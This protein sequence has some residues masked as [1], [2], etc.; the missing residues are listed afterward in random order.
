MYLSATN[1]SHFNLKNKKISGFLL[2]VS[3]ELL[4]ID[5]ML[6]LESLKN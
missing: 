4:Y 5:S 6:H 1:I 2:L 3:T